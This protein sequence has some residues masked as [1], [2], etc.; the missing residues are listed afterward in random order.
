[1]KLEEIEDEWKKDGKFDSTALDL[2]AQRIPDL[3]HKYYKI[4]AREQLVQKKY[5]MDYHSMKRTKLEYYK[6]QL[7]FATLK[8]HGWQQ[9]NLQ[10]SNREIDVYLESDIELGKL[11]FKVEAQ[12]IKIKYLESIMSTIAFR[13]Q[14]IKNAIDFLKFTNGVV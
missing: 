11:A 5:Q 3:H 4:Y 13:N 2:E 1:M 10:L 6:G 12:N 7:D 14:S 8:Q 9:F